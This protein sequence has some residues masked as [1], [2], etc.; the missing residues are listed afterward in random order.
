VRGF[1]DFELDGTRVA[2][3]NLELRFPFINALGV[4]GPIPLG[5]FNLRGVLFMDHA[6]A[7][8]KGDKFRLSAVDDSGN[9]RLQDLKMSF[10]GGVR[11]VLAFLV[12]KL[13]VAWKTDLHRSS[14]PLYHFSLGPEF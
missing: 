6:V 8:E 12:L 3:T 14:S 10:G 13:D 11:S 5:F 2:F 7:L 1:K 4:V 9:R